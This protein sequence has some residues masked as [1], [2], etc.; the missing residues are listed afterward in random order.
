MALRKET[1]KLLNDADRIQKVL[2]DLSKDYSKRYIMRTRDVTKRQLDHIIQRYAL[3]AGVV[4]HYLS[5]KLANKVVYVDS[6]QAEQEIVDEMIRHQAIGISWDLVFKLNANRNMKI[7]LD[8]CK[9]A[10]LKPTYCDNLYGL[11]YVI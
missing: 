8:Q 4:K 6:Q 9:D 11:A 1:I 7:W 5:G 2:D 3:N 10:G